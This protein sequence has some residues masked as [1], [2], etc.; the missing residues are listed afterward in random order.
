MSAYDHHDRIEDS[1]LTRRE[2]LSRMGNGFALL[3]L[4]GILGHELV[5]SEASA[6]PPKT[7]AAPRRVIPVSASTNP[8]SP[9]RA[10]LP[11]KAKRVIFLFA[12]GGPS[13]VDT[14][15]PKPKLLSTLR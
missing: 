6:A 14:F 8:L 12:N 1:F 10:P 11:A 7:G 3:G 2:L 4:A 13:Q 15:D 9:R 5:G